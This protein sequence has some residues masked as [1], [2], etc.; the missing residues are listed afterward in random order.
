MIGCIVS[1]TTRSFG[2]AFRTNI[3]TTTNVRR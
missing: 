2:S 1:W 3:T